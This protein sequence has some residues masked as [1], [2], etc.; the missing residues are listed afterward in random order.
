ME[1]ICLSVWKQ[2]ETVRDTW[3]RILTSESRKIPKSRSTVDG[4][5]WSLH[6]RK[7]VVGSWL[8][9]RVDEHHRISVLAALSCS[10]FDDIQARDQSSRVISDDLEWPWVE[11]HLIYFIF[12]TF[13]DSILWKLQHVFALT[14]YYKLDYSSLLPLKLHN[15]INALIAN[16]LVEQLT[17][18]IPV[19]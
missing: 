9:R 13:L 12:H 7:G 16:I 5:T 15:D 19:V 1:R 6:A 18:P 3:A 14:D 2:R 10:R 8:C 11:G 4:V 17:W